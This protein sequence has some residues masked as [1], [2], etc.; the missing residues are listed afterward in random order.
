MFFVILNAVK[1]LKINIS[2]SFTSL[3]SGNLWTSTIILIFLDYDI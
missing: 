1:N 3:A 2:E